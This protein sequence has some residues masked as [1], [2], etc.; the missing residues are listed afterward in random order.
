M[1][2]ICGYN[3]DMIY[4]D[5][6]DNGESV[7]IESHIPFIE[8]TVYNNRTGYVQVLQRSDAEKLIRLFACPRCKTVR[9]ED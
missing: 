1:K 9:M 2:C 3:S 8:L 4:S 5:V 7:T 6:I